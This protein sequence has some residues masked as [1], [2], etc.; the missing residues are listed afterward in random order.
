MH[1]PDQEDL[2]PVRDYFSRT[3]QECE[4]GKYVETAFRS[5]AAVWWTKENS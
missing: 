1:K 2:T 4:S 3:L 5:T